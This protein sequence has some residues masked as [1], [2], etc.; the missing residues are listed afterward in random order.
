MPI[1]VFMKKLLTALTLL[2]MST[3]LW[4]E[5]YRIQVLSTDANATVDKAFKVR[6]DASKYPYETV[7]KAGKKRICVGSYDSYLSALKA[8][9]D[10]RCKIATDAFIVKD[11][12]SAPAVKVEKVPEALAVIQEGKKIPD[13]VKTAETAKAEMPKADAKVETVEKEEAA[14]QP[15]ICIC[16]KHALRKAEITNALSYYKNSPHYRF[17]KNEKDWFE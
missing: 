13:A 4:A 5:T 11:A 6:L 8:L 15:C 10:V 12:E 7:V 9:R 14:A 2:V 17:G 16:D 1:V 3:A